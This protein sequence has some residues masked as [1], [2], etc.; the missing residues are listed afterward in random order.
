MVQEEASRDLGGGAA[1]RI[2]ELLLMLLTSVVLAILINLLTGI[3]DS[4]SRNDFAYNVLY[5]VIVSFFLVVSCVLFWV[6]ARSLREIEIK[7][8]S[9]FLVDSKL[10]EVPYIKFRNPQGNEIRFKPQ[11]YLANAFVFMKVNCQ[12]LAMRE[13][14]GARMWRTP[15]VPSVDSGREERIRQRIIESYRVPH[16]ATPSPVFDLLDCV[17]IKHL[18]N[19]MYMAGRY[20]IEETDFMIIHDRCE[21]VIGGFKVRS[22]TEDESRRVSGSDLPQGILRVELIEVGGSDS[23]DVRVRIPKGMEIKD[24]SSENIRGINISGRGIELIIEYER[25]RQMLMDDT[26][27][28]VLNESGEVDDSIVVEQLE[29]TTK[30]KMT[31]FGYLR[32]RRMFTRLVRWADDYS[33]MIA[34]EFDWPSFQ[35]RNEISQAI[36]ETFELHS[37]ETD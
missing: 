1:K 31:V 35:A 2:P 18:Q 30:I 33:S 36:R 17:L 12:V 3:I 20:G 7:T 23:T 15:P 6:L 34:S 11:I 19:S 32:N 26:E 37:H 29:I 10:G 9:Q 13:E 14:Y 4:W 21:G 25:I 28:V 27:I 8:V 5:L 22:P 24:I 16:E